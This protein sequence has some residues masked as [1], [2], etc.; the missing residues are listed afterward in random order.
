MTVLLLTYCRKHA[1]F[2]VWLLKCMN[3]NIHIDRIYVE[4]GSRNRLENTAFI[5]FVYAIIDDLTARKTIDH[6]K[7]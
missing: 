4:P 2:T 6:G 3:R 5:T 1:K 7:D